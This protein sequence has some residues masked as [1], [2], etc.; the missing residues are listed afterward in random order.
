MKHNKPLWTQMAKIPLTS[1][2][3]NLKYNKL[4]LFKRLSLVSTTRVE[5]QS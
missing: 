4:T 1:A 2:L 3:E 5:G